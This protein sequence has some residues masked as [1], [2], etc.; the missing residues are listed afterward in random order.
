[1]VRKSDYER[2]RVAAEAMLQRYVDLANSGDAGF[3]YP[4]EEPEVIALRDAL[5]DG[6]DSHG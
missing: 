3:W 6:V 4:E 5:S 1:M 2:L